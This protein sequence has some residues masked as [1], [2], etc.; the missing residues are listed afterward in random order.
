MYKL[1]IVL[2][3]MIGS[4]LVIEFDIIN[5]IDNSEIFNY[6]L[7]ECQLNNRVGDLMRKPDVPQRKL[8]Q[9]NGI[10][11]HHD[12]VSRD[13]LKYELLFEHA[14]YHVQTH[15]WA[16]IAYHYYI[17]A[18]GTMYQTLNLN[19][20]GNH[21]EGCNISTIAICLRGNF[22]K[23]KPTEPQ[24]KALKRLIKYLEFQFDFQFI[25]LHRDKNS[26]TSCPGANFN[27]NLIN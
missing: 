8:W 14:K 11:I 3:L 17:S 7:V 15:G 25:A 2:V 27:L 26:D 18:N 22:D 21:T 6:C 10:V 9:I 1:L 4:Y 23:E 13:S 24:I 12:A 5:Q 16:S 20:I 19:E